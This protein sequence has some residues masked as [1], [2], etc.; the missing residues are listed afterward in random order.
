MQKCWEINNNDDKVLE[1]QLEVWK[2]LN[3]YVNKMD[4]S[5]QQTLVVIATLFT[6]LISIITNIDNSFA[7]ILDEGMKP[8]IVIFYFI[9]LVLLSGIIFIPFLQNEKIRKETMDEDRWVKEA[10]DDIISRRS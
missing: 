6:I 5:Y 9:C 1:H 4:L 8:V 2:Y 10:K 3:A 7:N